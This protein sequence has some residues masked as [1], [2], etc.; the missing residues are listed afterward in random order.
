MWGRQ[1]KLLGA[2]GQEVVSVPEYGLTLPR[3]M[4][5]M[6]SVWRRLTVR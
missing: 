6:L 2:L 3:Q 1:E 5:R 4:A